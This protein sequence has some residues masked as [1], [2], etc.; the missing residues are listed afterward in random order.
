MKSPITIGIRS[1]GGERLM[2]YSA[3][4]GKDKRT[5]GIEEDSVVLEVWPLEHTPQFRYLFLSVRR[6]CADL[7]S[8]HLG[9]IHPLPLH[10]HCLSSPMNIIFLSVVLYLANIGK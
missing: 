2:R 9:L 8:V 3:S 10:I 4:G 1:A 5:L 7:L 6:H